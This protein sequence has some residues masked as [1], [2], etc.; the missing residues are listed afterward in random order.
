MLDTVDHTVYP[1]IDFRESKGIPASSI[2]H[3]RN[4]MG[5]QHPRTGMTVIVGAGALYVNLWNILLRV[6]SLFSR[7]QDFKFVNTLEE[8]HNLL[9]EVMK[10]RAQ[11]NLPSTSAPVGNE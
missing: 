2:T 10:R 11:S 4:I 6:Y 5:K 3:S 1:I 9:A 7:E 8:A